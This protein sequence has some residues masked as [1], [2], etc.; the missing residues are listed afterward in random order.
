[1]NYEVFDNRQEAARRLAGHLCLNTPESIV[2]A[3]PTRGV[4]V[5]DVLSEELG[6]RFDLIFPEKI[7]IPWNPRAAMGA[8]SSDGAK[9]VNLTMAKELGLS[10]K[11]VEEHCA[12]AESI[13][14]EVER[15][16]RQVIYPVE[17]EDEYV[18]L[19]DD[20]ISSGYTVLAA[21]ESLKRR[22]PARL[23]VATPVTSI[24][25]ARLLGPKVDEL[26]AL[27]VSERQPFSIEDFY[28]DNPLV[29]DDMMI[30]YLWE[31]RSQAA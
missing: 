31:N 15:K 11:A 29:D 25:A 24:A 19:V 10:N 17:V 9:I 21:V 5:G 7:P 13:A 6:C 4:I 28:F 26:I 3:I 12:R 16:Y 20:G 1:M 22:S 2:V 8:V 30:R 18:I 27:V 14:V 23:T